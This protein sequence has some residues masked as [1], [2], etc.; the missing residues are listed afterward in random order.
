MEGPWH[1]VESGAA[2]QRPDAAG[3]PPGVRRRVAVGWAFCW[4]LAR[5]RVEDAASARGARPGQPFAGS[6]AL[7]LLCAASLASVAG[8][9]VTRKWPV[10]SRWPSRSRFPR[11]APDAVRCAGTR[12]DRERAGDSGILHPCYRTKR[13][14]ARIVGRPMLRIHLW[15]D[16]RTHTDIV[17]IGIAQ[18]SKPRACNAQADAGNSFKRHVDCL[19]PVSTF[20]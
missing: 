9:A 19:L 11:R 8:V 7:A 3:R 20:A 13:R 5:R 15:G 10:A 18:A 6:A 16:P 4:V 12:T 17:V 1:R 14:R 2:G